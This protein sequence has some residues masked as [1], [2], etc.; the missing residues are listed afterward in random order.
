[1]LRKLNPQSAV[2]A[3][4]ALCAALLAA[5]LIAAEINPGELR[6]AGLDAQPGAVCPLKHTDVKTDIYGF[7]AR[8]TV[9]QTFE[10]P[11]A[12][13]IEALYVFPLP[14]DAAVDGM[15]MTVGDRLVIGEIKP[16]DEAR[17]AYEAAKAAGHVA[18]LLDQER[19][20][21]FTQAVANIEP[22]AQV[23]IEISFVETLKFEEGFYE[24][25]FPMVV[26]PRY[27]PG[28]GSAPAPLA[29]GQ[30]T[31][32]VPDGDRITPPV[33]PPGTRAGHDIGLTVNVIA[34]TDLFDI[35][36][37]LHATRITS[38]GPGRAQIVLQNEREIPNR[39][40]VLRY[41]L[42]TEEIEDAFLVD[43]DHNGQF[44]T[45][46]L[47][48]PRRI[49][50]EQ[51]VPRELIFVLDTSGSMNGTP[52]EKAKAAMAL[53]IGNLRPFDTF[54]LITFAGDT[55]VLWEKPRPASSQNVAA[56]QQF[57]ASRQGRGGT[58]M[59]KAIRAALEQPVELQSTGITP[60][61]L[62]DLPADGREVT[63]ILDYRTWSTPQIAQ[64][65]DSGFSIPV[66]D[67]V[68]I[69]VTPG[70]GKIPFARHGRVSCPVG[71]S[72]TLRGS[73]ATVSGERV[74]LAREQGFG[75]L[76]GPMRV[77]CFMTDGYVGNDMAIIDAVRKNAGTTRVFSFGIG[78]SVNRFLLDGMAAAGRGEVEYVTL[79]SSPDESVQ[80][81][82]R[83]IDAPVLSDVRID[84][85]TLPVEDVQPAVIPDLFAAKPIMVHGRLRG[86][87]GGTITL[88]GNT[89]AG[90]FQRT[91]EI[92]PTAA[93]A[94][95]ERSTLA[96]LWAR[97]KV[98][99]LMLQDM[100]GLQSGTFPPALKA[101][102]TKLG[103][104]YG[105]MTQFTSF[106]AVEKLRVTIGGQPVTVDVPVEMPDGVTY[107]GVFGESL[108]QS[109]SAGF[110]ATATPAAAR[111]GP[112]IGGVTG[113]PALSR[114]D[115]GPR[116]RVA[117]LRVATDDYDAERAEA[118]PPAKLAPELEGIAA[119]VEKEGR[120]GTLVAD[121]LRVQEYR[122]AVMIYLQDSG[123]E[124]R[125]ALQKLGFELVQEA[126]AVRALIG[127]I[128]VRKL[129]Q[130]AALEA[131]IRVEPLKQQ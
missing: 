44:F 78:N 79:A 36:T 130:L 115:A 3:A 29:K 64:A 24:W 50:P 116:E 117:K 53:A 96:S 94:D 37:P 88:S 76:P 125:A 128:D 114:P 113:K 54:N 16:R 89:G 40:F 46:I 1:M 80:R 65:D 69:R 41:R 108:G 18:S 15:R 17:A 22:G 9:K 14:Q 118:T 6:I 102:I 124:V 111:G 100:S 30:A 38:A 75:A 122:L 5:P 127:T 56:A 42:S 119:R 81:F 35:A 63:L 123:A 70:W 33:S 93:G 58:E 101:E 11:L 131:V 110:G 68:A 105:L 106:V 7:V 55:A 32:A 31:N 104:T 12:R 61:A 60:A 120:G 27:I 43:S 83:R 45:L 74:L 20:N 77:V 62:A 84:W 72:K 47:Q 21:I 25:T 8:T 90:P 19:P 39:D 103:V 67:G 34:G 129:E 86:A 10:N 13:K 121:A 71:E 97:A 23:S 109:S 126:G 82:A 26:G 49:V 73:W 48:P 95:S 99:G 51:V 91:V 28:G 107:D 4:A 112:A 2:K 52:I 98:A 85:G 57:L 59:M 92:A 66:R 87:A